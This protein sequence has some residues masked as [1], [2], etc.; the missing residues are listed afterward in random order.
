MISQIERG[1]VMPSVNTLY[2]ITSELGI[3]LDEL[4]SVADQSS[5]RETTTSSSPEA[6][7]PDTGADRIG[8]GD[9]SAAS[10]PAGA[11]RG[12]A[13]PVV[14]REQAHALELS[15]GVRWERL[16]AQPD[17][18]VDFLRATYEPGS[19]STPETALMRHQG[20]EYG[21]VIEGELNVT[22]GFET[23]RL[24][25]GDSISFDSSV[26]HRLFNVGEVPA[27]AIWFVVGR[28]GDY[29]HDDAEPRNG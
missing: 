12:G 25:A 26:P 17:P 14:R 3:S 9:R 29:R 24:R 22:V 8:A 11:Q 6:T 21:T 5:S 19:E 2:S 1:R 16:T 13:G 27:V 15:S 23:F 10:A 7:E 20:R 18:S 4:F 28:S